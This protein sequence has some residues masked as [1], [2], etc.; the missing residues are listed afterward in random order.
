MTT[1]RRETVRPRLGGGTAALLAFAGCCSLMPLN[2]QAA[3]KCAVQHGYDR[4]SFDHSEC[5]Q[6]MLTENEQSFK[7]AM[8]QEAKRMAAERAKELEEAKRRDEQEHAKRIKDAQESEKRQR[9]YEK[10]QL[11]QQLA[12]CMAQHGRGLEQLKQQFAQEEAAL[13]QLVQQQEAARKAREAALN[14]QV[15]QIQGG[16][17]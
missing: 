1:R 14:Q 16:T 12:G 9:D 2:E 10:K 17:P 11:E 8:S 3:E 5:V 7:D 4:G 15:Q 6:E 13:N